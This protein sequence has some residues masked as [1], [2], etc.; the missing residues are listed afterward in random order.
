MGTDTT[1][2]TVGPK[3]AAA[4]LGLGRVAV[5][6]LLREG[7]LPAVRVGRHYRIPVRALEQALKR[8]ESLSLPDGPRGW[9]K[10]TAR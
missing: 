3:E 6:R 7:R 8:P 10:E 9:R 1:S 4:R 5:Y 2:L